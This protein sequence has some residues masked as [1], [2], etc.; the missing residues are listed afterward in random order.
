[1]PTWYLSMWMMG[2]SQVWKVFGQ[3]TLLNHLAAAVK[4]DTFHHA[5]LFTGPERTGKKLM[6]LDLAKALN[7]EF[8]DAPCGECDSCKRIDSLMHADIWLVD[9]AQHGDEPENKKT[10]K[11]EEI[12]ELQHAANLP[13]FEGRTRVFIIDGAEAFTSSAANRLLKILEEPPPRVVFVLLAESGENVLPT[14][15][16]RC[17]Q[18]E[19][20]HVAYNDLEEYLLQRGKVDE[21][22]AKML[23]HLSGGRPGWAIAAMEDENF[24]AD[25]LETRN[26]ILELY[27]ASR[28]ERFDYAENAAT[29][30]AVDRKPVIAE[31]KCWQS[32]TRDILFVQYGLEEKVINC[33]ILKQLKTLAGL[34]DPIEI[35]NILVAVIHA[36]HQLY[37]NVNPRLVLE[38]L[39]LAL[40]CPGEVP[41]KI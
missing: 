41:V 20:R 4:K 40:E 8:K 29:R 17:Q 37:R 27:S 16:S 24:L 11:N 2:Y 30:F 35:R 5:Y 31:L 3:D 38:A 23:A 34:Y 22:E 15:A 7:C 6:A 21:A 12:E 39:V 14:I 18:L 10:I 26:R 32:L 28:E 1:M 25:F 33:D 36:R 19:F 9:L 13:P